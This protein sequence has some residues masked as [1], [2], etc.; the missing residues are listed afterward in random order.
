M[1]LNEVLRVL[2]RKPFQ[3]FSVEM[4]DGLSYSVWHPDQVL[5]SLRALYVGILESEKE[6]VAED[7]AICDPMHVTRLVPLR[8][9][10]NGRRRY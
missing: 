8:A 9:R 7:I 4:S 3:P 6:L 2:H 5:P 10:R 1:T